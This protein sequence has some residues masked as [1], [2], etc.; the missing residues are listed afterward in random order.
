MTEE[1]KEKATRYK[2]E[3]RRKHPEKVKEYN[4]R[5]RGKLRKAAEEKKRLGA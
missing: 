5:Y 3:W 4:D 1:A 2:R